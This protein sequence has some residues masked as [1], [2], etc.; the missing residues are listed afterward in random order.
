MT[1]PLFEKRSQS[2]YCDAC[3]TVNYSTRYQ[4]CGVC[5]SPAPA[6][7]ERL[8][9][10]R[11][12]MLVGGLVTGAALLGTGGFLLASSLYSRRSLP[13]PG[14]PVLEI[15]LD[16]GSTLS[17]VGESLGSPSL[18]WSSDGS[19]IACSAMLGKPASI[20]V[21]VVDVKSSQKTWTHQEPGCWFDAIA[22]SPD[23]TRL[24]LA[25]RSRPSSIPRSSFIQVWQVQGWQ[26]VAEYPVSKN[27]QGS[28]ACNQLAWSPDGT[29]LAGFN[30]NN[31]SA[32]S[33]SVQVWNASNGQVLFHQEV[34]SG[35]NLLLGWL[36]DGHRLA[37]S[38]QQ[39]ELDI[40]DTRTGEHLFHRE[41]DVPSASGGNVPLFLSGPDAAL[42]PDGQRAA[43]YTVEQ[44]QLVIQIWDLGTASPLFSCQPVAGQHW[45]LTWSS[46]GNYLAACQSNRSPASLRFWNV[47][48][49]K[50][51]F[52]YEA[53]SF[54]DRL[55]WSPNGRF[56]AMVDNRQPISLTFRAPRTNIVLRVLEIK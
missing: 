6:V 27:N 40:W 35:A 31:A 56:L 52:S 28:L 37:T 23:G 10:T 38:W 22:W 42:S 14:Q 5:C 21:I 12:T 24:A 15:L 48:T 25:G 8:H 29:R 53:L 50:L 19:H 18:A 13:Q 17:A 43:L 55:T 26:K 33:S 32:L 44:G 36:S 49:G 20:G 46:D 30:E 54:P 9:T 4:R 47:N 11:R 2:W 39:G 41:P 51:A 34:T 1:G 3:G 16:S 45:C 7:R